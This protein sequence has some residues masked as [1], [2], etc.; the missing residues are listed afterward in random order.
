M[1]L[2]IP[3]LCSRCYSRISLPL[4]SLT[5][6]TRWRNFGRDKLRNIWCTAV[7]RKKVSKKTANNGKRYAVWI[8]SNLSVRVRVKTTQQLTSINCPVFDDAFGQLHTQMEGTV[9]ALRKPQILPQRETMSALGD[10][11]A[12]KRRGHSKWSGYCLKITKSSHAIVIA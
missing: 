7:W 8:L 3:R 5:F 11:A 1:T 12:N 10:E 6:R 2:N 4:I 9:F